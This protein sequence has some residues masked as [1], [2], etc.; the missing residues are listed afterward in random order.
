MNLGL[1]GLAWSCF[2]APTLT[3]MPDDGTGTTVIIDMVLE[4]VHRRGDA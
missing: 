2:V 3:A 1:E 4:R